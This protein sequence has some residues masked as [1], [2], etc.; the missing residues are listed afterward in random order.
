MARHTSRCS[1]SI[2]YR[3]APDARGKTRLATV[4]I[5]APTQ[6][7]PAEVDLLDALLPLTADAK[8]TELEE[9]Q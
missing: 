3:T 5:T 1:L 9:L 7:H 6:I 4:S 8:L 2:Q